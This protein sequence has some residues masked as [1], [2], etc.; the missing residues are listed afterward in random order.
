MRD[1]R[2][3]SVNK[4]LIYGSK[5]VV[6]DDGFRAIT[7]DRAGLMREFKHD[8]RIPLQNPRSS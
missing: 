1:T 4:D 5:M 6:G 3:D 7:K 8:T 2:G